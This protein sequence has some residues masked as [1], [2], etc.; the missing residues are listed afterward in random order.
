MF[1]FATTQ[2]ME[3]GASILPFL[4]QIRADPR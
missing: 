4:A 2:T 3:L 1:S